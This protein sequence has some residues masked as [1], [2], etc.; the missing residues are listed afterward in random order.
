MKLFLDT[1]EVRAID[2]RYKTGL[3]DGVTTNPTL[4]SKLGFKNARDC[5][6][7][8]T[9]VCPDLESVSIEVHPSA[10]D[11]VDAMVLEGADYRAHKALTT[12]LPC[13]PA[14]LTACKILSARGQK[15]NVTLVFSV[16]QAILAAK[17][18]A[19]Y[20][21]PFVG[22]CND[23]SFSGV[24]LVRA[25]ASVYREHMVSTQILAAS[26]RDVH[27]VGRLFAV[28]ADVVTIPPS[29]FDKMYDHVL[30]REGLEKFKADAAAGGL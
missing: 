16:A 22:R 25:I 30:T 28:G 26:V 29:V 3:I 24:E 6:L 14:G 13:T 18:G 11:D 5:V 23:N 9:T 10:C 15:T 2:R 27:Q 7:N 8:I 12:K 20:V 4:I 17:A 19:T 1:A 21:S